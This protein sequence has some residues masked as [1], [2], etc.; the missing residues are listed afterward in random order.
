MCLKLVPKGEKAGPLGL[1]QLKIA[2]MFL[3]Q[4]QRY[5]HFS[6]GFLGFAKWKNVTGT[7]TKGANMELFVRKHIKFLLIL[8]FGLTYNFGKQVKVLEFK[9]DG[10]PLKP[11]EKGALTSSG[12]LSAT[13]EV[14]ICMRLMTR[15]R[16]RFYI[17]SN[18]ISLSLKPVNGNYFILIG[19]EQLN[20]WTFYKFVP[21]TPICQPITPGKWSSFCVSVQFTENVQFITL[22]FN[23]QLC[24][25]KQY[26]MDDQY[27]IYSEKKIALN[28]L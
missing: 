23:G 4:K 12:D 18:H 14:T 15:Y 17:V 24:Y 2:S 20:G 10:Y 6:L 22:V 9:P 7:I 16:R 28:E 21:I 13:K 1:S 26:P 3:E 27:W 19:F 5:F 8:F 11:I 25:E